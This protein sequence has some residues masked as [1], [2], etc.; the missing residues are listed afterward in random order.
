MCTKFMPMSDRAAITEVKYREETL[1][2][3]KRPY[4][5]IVLLVCDMFLNEFPLHERMH[6]EMSLPKESGALNEQ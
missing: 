3:N 5:P 4:D 2:D 6:I 1:R